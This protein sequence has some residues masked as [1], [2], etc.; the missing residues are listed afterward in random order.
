MYLLA[1]VFP[2]LRHLRLP[3]SR[4]QAMLLLLAFMQ[5]GIGVEVY[6]GHRISGSIV[7]NEWIPIIF[8]PAA[9]LLLLAAG[10]IARRRRDLASV[11]ATLTFLASILVGLLGAYFH[12]L[13]AVRLDAPA[14]QQFSWDLLVWA[15][16]VIAP[17][18]FSLIGVLGI[19]AVWREDPLDTGTLTLFRDRRLHMPFSKTRAYFFW[20]GLAM[21]ATVISSVL[22]HARVN[23][24]N[25]W[26]WAPTLVGVFATVVTVYLGMLSSPRRADLLVYLVALGLMLAVGPI[27]AVLHIQTDLTAGGQVVLERLIRGAPVMA[28]LLFANMG[29]LGLLVLMNPREPR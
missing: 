25:P 19:S 8:G 23:F 26:L 21:L 13:R 11:I 24:Q 28:P 1:T 22:D 29:L 20:V 2:G 18:M 15:P 10:L 27:G 6:T 9:C 16:P 7:P 4:D 12:A 3:I 14:G 17:L 5:L